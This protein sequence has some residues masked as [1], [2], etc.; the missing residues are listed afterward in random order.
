MNDFNREAASSSY[1]DVFA[2]HFSFGMAMAAAVVYAKW[3]GTWGF[4]SLMLL[5]L[6]GLAALLLFG[7]IVLG[8]FRGS[9]SRYTIR[10]LGILVFVLGL[11]WLRGYFPGISQLRWVLAGAGG[12]ALLAV[13]VRT[14]YVAWR[15]CL[16]SLVFMG[17]GIGFGVWTTLKC[18]TF[19][20]Y[21]S[22]LTVE[23]FERGI[24]PHPD[25][26]FFTSMSNMIRYYGVPSTGLQGTPYVSYHSGVLAFF[27]W[28][29]NLLNTQTIVLFIVGMPLLVIPLCYGA[30]LRCALALQRA[31]G[32]LRVFS[33]FMATF[34]IA[35]CT[36]G[37]LSASTDAAAGVWRSDLVSASYSFGLFLLFSMTEITLSVMWRYAKSPE[38]DYGALK[39]IFLGLGFLAL[40]AAT[41]FSKGSVGLLYVCC[42]GFVLARSGMW[43]RLPLA[44]MAGGAASGF[45]VAFVFLLE[46]TPSKLG[47]AQF[48]LA[49]VKTE[50]SIYLLIYFLWP[51]CACLVLVYLAKHRK[52]QA[53]SFHAL[54]EAILFLVVLSMVPGLVLVLPGGNADYFQN[55]SALV[56]LA[57][58]S[59]FLPLVLETT[60][61]GGVWQWPLPASW[62]LTLFL[63]WGLG[64]GA[65]VNALVYYRAVVVHRRS[66]LEFLGKAGGI[67]PM[68]GFLA[69][70][71]D[72][73]FSDRSQVLVDIPLS[74]A[75]YW[76]AAVC[77]TTP[78]IMPSF[79]G[80]AFLDGRPDVHC[81]A[82]PYALR[83][84]PPR[85]TAKEDAKASPCSKRSDKR[86][87]YIVTLAP[88]GSDWTVTD[89]Q[90]A[91]R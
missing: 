82:Q 26:L 23:A 20:G 6:L 22:P 70:L 50:W 85:D 76:K 78:F 46:R 68:M 39:C 28:L 30:M 1:D 38:T 37:F 88:A 49:Y 33:S 16:M 2:A 43:R 65:Y 24:L 62:A 83:S 54:T 84:Y 15:M 40:A 89:C 7:P 80:F 44:I 42:F 5:C 73:P 58:L 18:Y 67:T 81:L 13:M 91:S 59:A 12:V 35:A 17:I 3:R 53:A 56:G 34:L 51:I 52:T 79:S 60:S 21:L 27:A 11:G 19:D 32:D 9:G 55:V 14:A 25:T 74:R 61:E 29:S 10:L 45:A 57:A 75:E 87:R 69:K 47:P 36:I 63:M 77:Q 31:F 71:L 41:T 66:E 72:L 64:V 86:F 48:F 4:S 8:S 90:Q